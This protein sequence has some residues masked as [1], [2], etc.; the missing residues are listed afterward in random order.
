MARDDDKGDPEDLALD[1][2]VRMCSKFE[3]PTEIA[4]LIDN[5][6]REDYPT[7]S[8]S[9]LH[10]NPRKEVQT[11]T[12]ITSKQSKM[13][14]MMEMWEKRKKSPNMKK[15]RKGGRKRY[16]NQKCSVGTQ[17]QSKFS[18]PHDLEAITQA[19]RENLT[20]EITEKVTEKVTESFNAILSQFGLQEIRQPK[21]DR[22]LQDKASKSNTQKST[23]SILELEVL[24]RIKKPKANRADLPPQQK[25]KS[26]SSSRPKK[27]ISGEGVQASKG[28][29][30]Q[31]NTSKDTWIEKSMLNALKKLKRTGKLPRWKAMKMER[32]CV[33]LLSL[34]Y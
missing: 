29:S 30:L 25:A 34:C 27:A 9:V 24:E 1:E 32:L 6:A 33:Y 15:K 19:V 5:N 2:V 28:S 11:T 8:S 23:S 26:I 3:H 20:E 4:P 17:S 31:E 21:L 14:R 18:L 10:T 7:I 16:Q 12:K 13:M 22:P